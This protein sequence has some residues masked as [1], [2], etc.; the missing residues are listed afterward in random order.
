MPLFG[1]TSRSNVINELQRLIELDMLR[2]ERPEDTNR[3]YYVRTQ[4]PLWGIV[5]V[6]S[7]IIGLRWD[8]DQV[9]LGSVRKS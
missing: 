5:E 2:E 3:V 4:S 7:E 8:R 6:A 9:A 1:T